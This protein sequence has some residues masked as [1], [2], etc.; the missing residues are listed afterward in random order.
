MSIRTFVELR[1]LVFLIFIR[2]IRAHAIR[3]YQTELSRG[4]LESCSAPG[5]IRPPATYEL[6]STI[7]HTNFI[8]FRRFQYFLAFRISLP[9]TQVNR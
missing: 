4:A 7:T 8:D 1:K 3:Y 9:I 2:P 5:P 6:A